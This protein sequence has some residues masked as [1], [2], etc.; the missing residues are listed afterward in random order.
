M[1]QFLEK[2]FWDVD[3]QALNLQK[4]A[5]FIIERILEEGDIKAIKW[6]L[7]TFPPKTIKKVL[8]T[9]RKLSKKSANFWAIIF[10][11]PKNKILCLKKSFQKTHRI[12]W[13][14]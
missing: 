8:Q 13:P 10:N 14:Y 4:D 2:Y 6:M 11:L 5:Y 7:R 9:S 1:P 3:F 12:A